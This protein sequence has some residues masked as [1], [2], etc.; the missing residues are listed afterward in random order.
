MTTCQAVSRRV[1]KLL[2]ER[3]MSQY[4]LELNSGILHGTMNNIMKG[5]N[6]SIKLNTVMMIACGFNMSITEFLN[7]PVFLSNEELEIE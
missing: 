5:N 7:D 6:K 2:D 3:N 1:K 4:R